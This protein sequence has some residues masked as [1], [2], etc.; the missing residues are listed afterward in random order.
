MGISASMICLPP[1]HGCHAQHPASSLVQISHDVTGIGIRHGNLQGHD[2]LQQN[3]ACF[4]DTLLERLNSR[5][6]KCHFRRIYRMIGSIIQ[7]RFDTNYRDRPPEV[8]LP[9]DS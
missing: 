3:G 1:A 6:L 7:Y 8:L 5:G 9:T 4:H 2:G